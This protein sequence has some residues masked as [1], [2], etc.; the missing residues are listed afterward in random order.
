MFGP[1]HALSLNIVFRLGNLLCK[2][3]FGSLRLF[4]AGKHA[5]INGN[6]K[7]GKEDLGMQQPIKRFLDMTTATSGTYFCATSNSH[8]M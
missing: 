2:L 6:E 3:H 8:F 5:K 4:P 1:A 7:N